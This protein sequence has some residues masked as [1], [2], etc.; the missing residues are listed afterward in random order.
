MPPLLPV[1]DVHADVLDPGALAVERNGIRKRGVSRITPS[2]I[3]AVP[4]GTA[5]WLSFSRTS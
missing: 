3:S 2:V 4:S 1:D 5:V